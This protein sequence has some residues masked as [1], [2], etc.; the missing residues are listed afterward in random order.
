MPGTG[1]SGGTAACFRVWEG[2]RL[3]YP[4]LTGLRP[5]EPGPPRRIAGGGGGPAVLERYSIASIRA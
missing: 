1:A 3:P 4:F 2:G 5:P